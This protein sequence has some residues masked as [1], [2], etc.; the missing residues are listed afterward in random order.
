MPDVTLQWWTTTCTSSPNRKWIDHIS[1]TRAG[2]K[3]ETFKNVIKKIR[4]PLE[5]AV[6]QPFESK[7]KKIFQ[8]AEGFFFDLK[9]QN[10]TDEPQHTGRR[11]RT[12][13]PLPGSK[14]SWEVLRPVFQAEIFNASTRGRLKSSKSIVETSK[15][16][17]GAVRDFTPI[18][19]LVKFH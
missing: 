8:R 11:R 13:A 14:G 2:T 10:F 18:D 16:F 15:I 1:V 5:N 17:K 3:K 19:S 4:L 7:V 12:V 6:N 9:P